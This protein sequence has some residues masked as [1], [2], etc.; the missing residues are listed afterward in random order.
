M[1]ASSKASPTG[2]EEIKYFQLYARI[3]DSLERDNRLSR[4]AAEAEARLIIQ[5][6]CGE[7][8][9]KIMGIFWRENVSVQ[10]AAAAEEILE[11]R[12]AFE[13][14]QYILGEAEFYGMNFKVSKSVLIPRHD[15]ECVVEAAADCV[16]KMAAP[17]GGPVKVLDIGTGSGAIAVA[18]AKALGPS[19][20]V[21]ALDVSPAAL[22][23]AAY[24]ARANGAGERIRFVESDLFS[25]LEENEKFD[26]IVSNP[27]YISESE[28]LT[29][30]REV[31]A[32]PKIALTAPDGG[33]YF[34]GRILREAG[35]RLNPGGT[36]VFEIGFKMAAEVIKIASGCGFLN[37]EIV[38]DIESR[39]RG[40]KFWR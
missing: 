28:Y 22:E 33:Y 17:A 31:F 2:G 26:L 5:K 13:P 34:Y 40:I 19:A 16:R 3:A 9:S 11:R 38:R 24:N 8:F 36:A 23:C 1:I 21:T 14:I 4:P 35:S 12:L 6:A 7:S 37:Y 29:L 32:E 25:G 30:A 39:D 27:P 20:A 10:A 15:T 18:L